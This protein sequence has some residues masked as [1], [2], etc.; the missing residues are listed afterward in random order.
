MVE[1]PQRKENS[2]DTPRREN[3]IKDG[4]I[5]RGL[6]RSYQKSR[7]GLRAFDV[8]TL[9]DLILA[10]TLCGPQRDVLNKVAP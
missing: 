9:L 2:R 5:K 8:S 1:M 7:R 10:L 3:L 6:I 4:S